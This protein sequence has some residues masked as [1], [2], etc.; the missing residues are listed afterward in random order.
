MKGRLLCARFTVAIKSYRVMINNFLAQFPVRWLMF[1][2]VSRAEVVSEREKKQ[3]W[4]PGGTQQRRTTGAVFFRAVKV[5]MLIRLLSPM[6][7]DNSRDKVALDFT[8]HV[9][10]IWNIG[11]NTEFHLLNFWQHLW[12]R[13]AALS[14]M[15]PIGK[16]CDKVGVK[17]QLRSLL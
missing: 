1:C 13:P 17:G 6:F 12:T 2:T 14:P 16:L 3:L 5:S 15:F 4:M 11:C 9:F 7:F 10:R 8:M